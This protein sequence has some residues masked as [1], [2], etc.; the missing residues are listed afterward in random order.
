LED[1]SLVGDGECEER[2]REEISRELIELSGSSFHAKPARWMPLNR[3][4][5]LCFTRATVGAA[6]NNPS[7]TLRCSAA[8]IRSIATARV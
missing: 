5:T 1:G 8:R 6:G 3:F 4:C 2:G 7:L